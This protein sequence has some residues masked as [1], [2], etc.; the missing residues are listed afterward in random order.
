MQ[1]GLPTT[2]YIHVS[3]CSVHHEQLGRLL[4]QQCRR[5][6]SEWHT[7][8]QQQ[9][10][11]KYVSFNVGAFYKVQEGMN[12]FHSIELFQPKNEITIK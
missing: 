8:S 7:P 9:P 3:P 6:T 1:L 10:N 12:E 5:K 4:N 2:I 11:Q